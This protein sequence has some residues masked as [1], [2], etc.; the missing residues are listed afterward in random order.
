MEEWPLS[1]LS[2]WRSRQPG[3]AR[4]REVFGPPTAR[5]PHPPRAAAACAFPP[6]PPPTQPHTFLCMYS[7]YIHTLR[8]IRFP[9]HYGGGSPPFPKVR[10]LQ[11]GRGGGDDAGST[12]KGEGGV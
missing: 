5:T 1:A 12:A 2:P 4:G 7:T 9:Q 11:G 3:Q 6:P 8:A 10:V